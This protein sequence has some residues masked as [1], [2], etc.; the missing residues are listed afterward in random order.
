MAA[1]TTWYWDM[2]KRRAVRAD[3]RGPGDEVLGP[4]PS[5][6][7]AE[8]WREKVERR[9]EDW[10]DADEQWNEWPDPS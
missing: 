4:Y 3:E 10:D 9:N 5:K 8:H 2:N 1:S 7:A 6:E